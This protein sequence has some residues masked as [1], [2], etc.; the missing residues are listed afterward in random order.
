MSLKMKNR[1]KKMNF[2]NTARTIE[3]VEEM[4]GDKYMYEFHIPHFLNPE[5]KGK[6]ND[7]IFLRTTR[8]AE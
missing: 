1:I 2:Q 4:K 6:V 7:E 5:L 8:R 3:S